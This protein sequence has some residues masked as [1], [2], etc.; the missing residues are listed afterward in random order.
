M[1]ARFPADSTSVESLMSDSSDIADELVD[2]EPRTPSTR[3]I[4]VN[5]LEGIL[6]EIGKVY[7]GMRAGTIPAHE[8][9]KL[10]YVLSHA[11]E[12][13]E[14][15][16]NNALEEKLLEIEARLGLVALQ[17]GTSGHRQLPGIATGA[18]RGNDD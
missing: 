3:K 11:R 2:D 10:T 18:D 7:R 12:V 8:G 9:T 1:S 5:T 13:V 17:G 15:I 14:A 6:K 16:A 4:R